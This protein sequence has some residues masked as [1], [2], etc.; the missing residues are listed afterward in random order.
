MQNGSLG[1]DGAASGIRDGGRAVIKANMKKK[2]ILYRLK[3][4]LYWKC[5]V[6]NWRCNGKSLIRFHMW[7]K[8][9][10]ETQGYKMVMPPNAEAN[11]VWCGLFGTDVYMSRIHEAIIKCTTSID[12]IREVVLKECKKIQFISR[13]HR[14][15]LVHSISESE[16]EYV[17]LGMLIGIAIVSVLILRK[18]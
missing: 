17:T 9:I 2:P 18:K 15:R 12:A 6:C 13:T 4:L 1:N 3:P 5:P 7:T 11:T 10:A 8:L 14:P 16:R